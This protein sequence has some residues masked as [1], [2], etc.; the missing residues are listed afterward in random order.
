[1]KILFVAPRYH[2]NQIPIIEGLIEKGNSVH[3][4]AQYTGI[5]EEHRGVEPIIMRKSLLTII[6]SAIRHAFLPGGAAESEDMKKFIPSP[7]WTLIT[8]NR[9]KPDLVITREKSRVSRIISISCRLAGIKNVILYVQD[10]YYHK[11][12]VQNLRQKIKSKILPK[13]IYTPVKYDA[14]N[15]YVDYHDE[16][17]Y[18]VPLVYTPVND[19]NS[20]H[21]KYV[22]GGVLHLLD[23]GKYR[24]YKYHFGAVEAFKLLPKDLNVS[25]TI[26]GQCES[27][28]EK[29]YKSKLLAK[30]KE[31]DLGDKITLL[32][33]VPYS[34]ITD[35]YK[36]HDML[37]LPSRSESAGMVILEAMG[38]GLG[39]ICTR[40]CGLA[41]CVEES[42][43][44]N[45][46][47]YDDPK[48]LAMLI[49]R[50]ACDKDLVSECANKAYRYILD[51]CSFENYMNSLDELISAEFK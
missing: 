47:A 19:T 46:Y 10:P 44:G 32:D 43:C 2:T 37:L 45:S 35:I 39:V 25:L 20:I 7:V 14:S 16:H 33:N 51:N 17:S 24:G 27:E 26:I 36:D 21:D 38:N 4:W 15:K 48:E 29:E 12:K 40:T 11:P 3:F 28:D 31:Y 30:I 13:V 6:A 8:L 1:M 50:Y 22:S 49:K 42:G 9:L 18:H 23:I 41:Y 34:Q 5:I